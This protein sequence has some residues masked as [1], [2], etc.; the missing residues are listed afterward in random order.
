MI[1]SILT[2]SNGCLDAGRFAFLYIYWQA[3]LQAFSRSGGLFFFIKAFWTILMI[4]GIQSF[5]KV[6]Q[7]LMTVF[8]EEDGGEEAED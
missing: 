8:R 7:Q 2:E 6:S 4:Y 1:L 5:H 3:N